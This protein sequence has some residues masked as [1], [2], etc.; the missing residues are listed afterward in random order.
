LFTWFWK[1]DSAPAADAVNLH[2][3]LKDRLPLRLKNLEK[4]C[5]FDYLADRRPIYFGFN[6]CENEEKK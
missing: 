1:S 6:R 2:D 5:R 4:A 3:R